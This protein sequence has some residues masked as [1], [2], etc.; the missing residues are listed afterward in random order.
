VFAHLHLILGEEIARIRNEQ[1][2]VRKVKIPSIDFPSLVINIWR[3]FVSV[4]DL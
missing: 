1:V 2:R 3:A 4:K